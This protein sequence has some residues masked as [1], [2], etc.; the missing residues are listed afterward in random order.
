MAGCQ[1][2][3]LCLRQIM[4]DIQ[5]GSRSLDLVITGFDIFKT[6]KYG[7]EKLN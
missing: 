2:K 7:F 6:L 1:Q 4:Q 3:L 5:S